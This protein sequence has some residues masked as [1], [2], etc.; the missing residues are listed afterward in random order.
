MRAERSR[1]RL[2]AILLTKVLP[3][4]SLLR[5]YEALHASAVRSPDGAVVVL[6]PSGTGKTALA[7]V[8]ARLGWPLLSDDIVVLGRGQGAVLTHPGT[9]HL[10]VEESANARTTRGVARV[11]G[12]LDGELWL[13]AET[14][15][16]DPCPVS[17]VCLLER[18]RPGPLEIRPLAQTPL[19]LAPY[20][21]GLGDGPGRERERFE[22]YSELMDGSRLLRICAGDTAGPH[23][24]ALS[25]RQLL[26]AESANA[27]GLR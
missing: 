15:C 10:N 25:L 14:P 5:G 26:A 1:H 20:M 2:A 12:V 16:G 3:N 21:L 18:G 17:A 6:A 7:L 19:A 22:L 27:G 9:P 4:V 23:R 8:L 13:T 24:I 11:L